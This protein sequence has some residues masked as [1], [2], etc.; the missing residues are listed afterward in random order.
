MEIVVEYR[1]MGSGMLRQR[2]PAGNR[3][4]AHPMMQVLCGVTYKRAYLQVGG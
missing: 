1:Y 4:A 3:S 2:E